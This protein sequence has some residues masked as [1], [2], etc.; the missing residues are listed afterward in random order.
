MGSNDMEIRKM[1]LE[2]TWQMFKSEVDIHSKIYEKI[3]FG[4]EVKFDIN[5]YFANWF[6]V[7]PKTGTFFIRGEARKSENV[8][9]ELEIREKAMKQW[10]L[11]NFGDDDFVSPRGM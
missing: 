3:R 9:T 4:V 8:F 6:N 2:E 10:L 1:S 5:D 7:K 11:E